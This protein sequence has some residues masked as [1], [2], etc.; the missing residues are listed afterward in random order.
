MGPSGSGRWERWSIGL[1]IQPRRP[2]FSSH[3]KIPTDFFATS[4]HW[5][6]APKIRR[7]SSLCPLAPFSGPE[8]Q[9]PLHQPPGGPF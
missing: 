4:G 2:R 5:G 1:Q 7:S 3:L 6:E 9:I 8:S